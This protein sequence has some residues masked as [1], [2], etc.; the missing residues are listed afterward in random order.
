MPTSNNE[1]LQD[2]SPFALTTARVAGRNQAIFRY[3]AKT[4][5]EI[6][7][8]AARL[9]DAPFLVNDTGAITYEALFQQAAAHAALF[10]GRGIVKGM[11]VPLAPHN[12]AGWIA[13]FIALTSLGATAVLING[14]SMKSLHQVAAAECDTAIVDNPPDPTQKTVISENG[15][16]AVQSD[17]IKLPESEIDPEQE[18]CIAFTSG[19]T[20]D[21]KGAILT[22]RGMTTGLMNMMLAGAM[23][24]RGAPGARQPM[25]RPVTPSVLLRTPLSHV[26]AYMQVLLMF[27]IGG[28]VVRSDRADICQLIAD[29]QITS[30]TGISDA[31]IAMLLAATSGLGPL[32]SIAVAGRSLPAKLR[33][34]LRENLP[35]L[36]VG[37]GYGLTETNGLVSA[38]SNSELDSRPLAVGPV[39][40]TVECRILGK[41]GEAC[42]AGESGQIS[43]RGA[44]LM[45]GYCN[46]PRHATPDDRS[47]GGWF[48][49]G[50]IGYL[51]NDG[52]LHVLDKSDR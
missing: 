37:S 33:R 39:L 40:P 18:A 22:H 42:S 2:N 7:R 47:T 30:V 9:K 10:A 38:I 15:S 4:L 27:M 6:Y 24:A 46:A 48:N 20:G 25:T 14:S 5:T 32:R 11:R 19:S 17:Q 49:T 23:A 8:K 13:S 52:Y 3:G 29:H 43:L 44:M 31:E 16:A 45:K 12:D 36:G 28:R 50:D 26:S 21:P 41:D 34:T 35:G 51:S 1:L